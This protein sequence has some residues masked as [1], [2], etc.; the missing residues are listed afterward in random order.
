M[1]TSENNDPNDLNLFYY[2][3]HICLIKDIDKYLHRN[4]KDRSS[5]IG[6]LDIS[7]IFDQIWSILISL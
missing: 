2:M 7:F 4:N 6:L 1:F 5:C 3:G